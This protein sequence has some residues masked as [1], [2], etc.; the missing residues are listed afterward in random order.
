MTET[1][2]FIIALGILSQSKAG[3]GTVYSLSES[4]GWLLFLFIGLLFFGTIGVVAYFVVKNYYEYL[5]LF[6][7]LA[8]ISSTLLIIAERKNWKII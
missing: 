3:A 6:G 8:I 5:I 4:L 1:I 2:L 7:V